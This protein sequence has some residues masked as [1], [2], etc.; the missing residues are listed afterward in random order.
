M[1]G[2]G[3]GRR[4]GRPKYTQW[5]S[6][7]FL[8]LGICLHNIHFVM[9]NI[10]WFIFIFARRCVCFAFSWIPGASKCG[11]TVERESNQF[12][13]KRLGQERL[14]DGASLSKQNRILTASMFLLPGLNNRFHNIYCIAMFDVHLFMFSLMPD[15]ACAL[16]FRGSHFFPPLMRNPRSKM[17]W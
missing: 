13:Y 16:L 15:V 4:R 17:L 10:H 14:R 2:S 1:V 11:Q 12:W 6:Y 5:S 9:F 3:G 7:I 8:G